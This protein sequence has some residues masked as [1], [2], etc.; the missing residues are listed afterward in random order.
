MEVQF[1]VSMDNE[2]KKAGNIETVTLDVTFD[3]VPEETIQKAALAHMVVAWQSQIRSHWTDFTEG[4]LPTEVTFGIP[5]F[6][7]KQAATLTPITQESATEYINSL[8][9]EARAAMLTKLQA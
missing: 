9:P 8:P 1:K 2:Q 4:K 3:G 7:P 5:L 6:A